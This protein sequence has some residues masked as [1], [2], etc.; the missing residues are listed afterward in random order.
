MMYLTLKRLEA[1]GSLQVRWSG[2]MYGDSHMEM[3]GRG[4]GGGIGYRTVRGWIGVGEIKYG[5]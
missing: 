5:L 2:E 1:P 4:Q 3:G